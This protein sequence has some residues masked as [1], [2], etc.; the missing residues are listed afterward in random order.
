MG[1]CLQTHTSRLDFRAETQRFRL[2]VLGDTRGGAQAEEKTAFHK[3]NA[4]S[5]LLLHS[6]EKEVIG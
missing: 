5:S 2:F 6:L 1:S 3:D 4:W